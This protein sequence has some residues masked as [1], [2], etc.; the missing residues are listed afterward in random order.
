ME[1][2]GGLEV[3]ATNKASALQGDDRKQCIEGITKIDQAPLNV[4]IG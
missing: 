1:L 2:G 4:S 3:S